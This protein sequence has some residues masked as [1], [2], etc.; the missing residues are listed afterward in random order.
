MKISELRKIIETAEQLGQ[1]DVE[2]VL[3]DSRDGEESLP[4]ATAHF[5]TSEDGETFL[6][7]IYE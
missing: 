6:G 4:K 2:L 5:I 3:V 1:C 7:V